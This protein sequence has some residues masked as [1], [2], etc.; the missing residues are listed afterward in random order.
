MNVIPRLLQ[1]EPF[2]QLV[3]RKICAI[4]EGKFVVIPSSGGEIRGLIQKYHVFGRAWFDGK[5][6]DS[7]MNRCGIS[8]FGRGKATGRGESAQVRGSLPFEA[9]ADFSGFVDICWPDGAGAENDEQFSEWYQS[10]SV[11]V[12]LECIGWPQAG[13]SL[14]QTERPF[15]RPATDSQNRGTAIG[16]RDELRSV[17]R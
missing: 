3:S 11:T 7:G 16:A 13:S 15:L 14:I 17:L 6:Q 5:K 8:F 12:V 1:Y 4:A 9:E 2:L 10:V